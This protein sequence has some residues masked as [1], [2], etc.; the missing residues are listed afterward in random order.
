MA[1]RHLLHQGLGLSRQLP[2]HELV[3]VEEVPSVV[4]ACR[5]EE[6]L[7]IASDSHNAGSCIVIEG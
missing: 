5:Q 4:Q 7:F 3:K 2:R 1:E 6:P